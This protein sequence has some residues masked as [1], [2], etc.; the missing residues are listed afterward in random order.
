MFDAAAVFAT[1][2]TIVGRKC[3]GCIQDIFLKLRENNLASKVVQILSSPS[4]AFTK[5]R[6]HSSLI[7]RKKARAG[8]IMRNQGQSM[9][10]ANKRKENRCTACTELEW[11]L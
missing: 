10:C 1:M 9:K 11:Q 7:A 2:Q 3:K 6:S 5:M 4:G 8:G